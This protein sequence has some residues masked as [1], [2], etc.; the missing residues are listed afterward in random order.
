[1]A[2][3]IKAKKRDIPQASDLEIKFARIMIKNSQKFR[4]RVYRKLASLLR[5][6]FSLMDALERIYVI[7]SRE[8]KDPK[9]SEAIAIVQWMRGLQNGDSFSV[10]LRGWAPSSELLMLSVGD[11]ANLEDALDNLIHVVEGQKKMKEPL[12]SALSYPMVLLLM[13][14]GIIYGVGAYMVPP[15]EAAAENI[16]W[17]G[18]AKSLIDLSHW[19]QAHPLLL[20]LTMPII[21]MV[22]AWTLPRWKGRVRASFDNVPPWSLYRIFVGVSWLLSLAALVKAGTPVS[23]ALRTLREDANPYLLYR[24]ER[25]LIF[26]NNGEN[27][28]QALALT[29]LGFPDREVIGDLQ[30]Y[31]ELDNFAAALDQMANEWLIDSIRTIE[32]KAAILNSIAILLIAIV[33]GWVVMGTFDMQDQ[34]VNAM[35]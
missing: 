26:V 10:A 2:E 22:I 27:L 17:G 25:A 19:V 1:M 29:G 30:I 23:K 13:V 3:D 18:M 24:I 21:F 35:G 4:L 5:N 6:R 9:S 7:E 15:M 31:S 34:L 32:Q 11:I 28:G 14:A 16:V 8:G 12:V 33:V 20:F